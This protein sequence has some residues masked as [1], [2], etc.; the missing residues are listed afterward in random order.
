MN[1]ELKTISILGANRIT[2]IKGIASVLKEDGIEAI[3]YEQKS[4]VYFD[5]DGMNL[6][7]C[8]ENAEFPQTPFIIFSE[9]WL[10]KLIEQV[11]N[12]FHPI[13][14]K[15]LKAS[16]SKL[17]LSNILSH[18]NIPFVHRK[19]LNSKNNTILKKGAIVRPDCAYSGKGVK[20]IRN[21]ISLSQYLQDVAPELS[22]TMNFVMPSKSI[23]YIEEEYIAGEEYSCDVIISNYG[24]KILRVCYK[25]IQWCHGSPSTRAYLTV[26]LSQEMKAAILSWCN[27]L[28]DLNF[29]L[30]FAQFDFIKGKDKL[31]YPIDFSAR[32]GSG[33][34]HLLSFALDNKNLYAEAILFALGRKNDILFPRENHA[35]FVY[36]PEYPDRVK[37][38]DIK[39]PF[40][41]K[42]VSNDEILPSVFTTPP[43]KKILILSR[44]KSIE[45]FTYLANNINEFVTVRYS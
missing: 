32:V 3:F 21:N 33:L 34:G 42:T 25:N 29:D 11:K 23:N 1:K 19:L 40:E 7:I 37:R 31:F 9:Y 20:Y 39:W 35:V 44:V 28:F 45:N 5:L 6:S 2:P 24:T 17:F 8:S 4:N 16:R 13:A 30:S 26:P 41:F 15:A 27:I 38:V 12:V 14:E 10:S 36:T 18:Y 22:G 43:Y